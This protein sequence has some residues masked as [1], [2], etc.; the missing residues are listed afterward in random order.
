MPLAHLR[1]GGYV[2]TPGGDGAGDV[3]DGRARRRVV[4]DR[5]PHLGRGYVLHVQG[6]L[7]G[8][9]VFGQA[10]RRGRRRRAREPRRFKV[11]KR[12]LRPRVF[13]RTRRPPRRSAEPPRAVGREL[14]QHVHDVRDHQAVGREALRGE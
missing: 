14:E 1:F 9:R 12:R 13:L 4:L 5:G 8:S 7:R 6:E 11:P 3:T 10:R 2:R